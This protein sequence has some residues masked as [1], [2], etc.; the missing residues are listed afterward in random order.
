MFH[1]VPRL[2]APGRVW[3]L[4]LPVARWLV[5]GVLSGPAMN[6]ALSF[7]QGIPQEQA[8][9]TPVVWV[10]WLLGLALSC[11]G[12]FVRPGGIHAARWAVILVDY[13]LVPRRAVWCPVKE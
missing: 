4:P 11:V 6:T 10:A 8:W 9:G 1:R 13:Q 12:A 2:D 5:A 3:L 7:F